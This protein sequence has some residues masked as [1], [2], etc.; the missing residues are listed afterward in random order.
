MAHLKNLLL[1]S[2]EKDENIFLRK[3]NFSKIKISINLRLLL[4][5]FLLLGNRKNV[6]SSFL[7]DYFYKL[8]NE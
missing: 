7:E 5:L 4:F 6:F 2:A 8:L 3:I 1:S